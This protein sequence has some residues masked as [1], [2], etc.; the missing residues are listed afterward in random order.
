MREID[1]L[2]GIWVGRSTGQYSVPDAEQIARSWV[3]GPRAQADRKL[4]REAVSNSL[5]MPASSL[6]R[7]LLT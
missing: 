5:P 6:S 2:D 3:H 1:A 4:Y 7:Q